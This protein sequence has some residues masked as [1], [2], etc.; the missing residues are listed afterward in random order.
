MTQVRTLRM[1]LS[2]VIALLNPQKFIPRVNQSFISL[3]N[4]QL[5]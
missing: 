5:H 2:L 3:L 1:S 4:T